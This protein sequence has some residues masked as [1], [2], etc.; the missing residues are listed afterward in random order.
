VGSQT[1]GSI[2]RP[3][4]YCGVVGYKPSHG[5]ISRFGVLHQSDTLDHVGVFAATVGDAAL[6]A[7]LL[8]H[9]DPGDSDMRPQ[10]R[11]ELTRL[12]AEEPPLPPRLAFV[13]SPV[14]D[15]A[16]GET[17]DAFAELVD[18]LGESAEEAELPSMFENAIDLHR[19]I[20]E[21]DVAVSYAPEYERGK[22]QLSPRLRE[23][24]ESGQRV[25]AGDYIRA[26][27]RILMLNASLVPL[28]DR[29]EAIVTP[30]TTGT[31]P[32][33]DSTGSPIFCTTWTLLGTPAI[34]LPILQGSDGLPLG[35]QLVGRRGEDGRL[36]RTARWLWERVTAS[37]RG[38]GKSK[39]RR[40]R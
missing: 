26:K 37:G 9:Y 33:L 19:T 36:L 10:A 3:A 14:W 1:N 24:I 2:I 29:F 13:T 11:A 4:A 12:A 22:E 23:I 20:F 32:E 27:A 5:L 39:K 17:A 25:L 28:F 38:R 31:A 8:M 21:A 7:E 30:A 18:F 34:T 40:A 6:L 15:K 16:E 35:V